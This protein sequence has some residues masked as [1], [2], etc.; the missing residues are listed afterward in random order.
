MKKLIVAV[1]LIVPFIGT[2]QSVNDCKG[3]CV[4]GNGT[5]KWTSGEKYVGEWVDGRHE[6]NGIFIYKVP[7]EKEKGI[8]Y[9]TKYAGEWVNGRHEGNGIMSYH[10][11]L[12]W[13]GIFR[14]GKQ[15]EGCYNNENC[16]NPEDVVG[17]KKHITIDLETRKEIPDHLVVSV[18]FGDKNQITEDFLFDTGAGDLKITEKFLKKLKKN[19]VKITELPIKD[20]TFGTSAGSASGRYVKID[21]ITIGE[22]TVNNVVVAVTKE[23]SFLFGNGIYKKFSK[24]SSCQGSEENYIELYK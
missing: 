11:G 2:S 10:N 1:F 22:Y 14:D 21:N 5:Y 12:T 6:G 3:D 17:N 8:I 15:L 24:W 4:N 9:P 13:T 23:G 16:Y 7:K 20:V 19:K 18:S